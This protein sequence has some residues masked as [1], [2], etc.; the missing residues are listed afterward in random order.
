MSGHRV[1]GSVAGPC[2]N[3]DH[4][5]YFLPGIGDAAAA[6]GKLGF[7]LTPFS[8]QSH[9]L[10]ANGPL[11]PAGTGNRCVMLEHGYL[12]FLAPTHDTPNA[13]QLRAAISRYTGVHLV[14]FGTVTP[15]ADHQR[16]ASAHF[17][18]LPPVALQREVGTEA[19]MATARFTVVRVP[20]ATMAEGRIQYCRHHTPEVV[21]QQRWMRHANHAI[22]LAGVVVC[23]ADAAEAAR[24]YA[25][26]TG[27]AA[28]P[29]GTGWRL[30][31]AR[32]FL[33]FA[34]PSALENTLGLRAAVL[35]WIAG[36]VLDCDDMDA[37]R[38][39]TQGQN[40]DGRLLVEPD[41]SLGG[42]MIFQPPDSEPLALA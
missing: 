19:G 21:W 29:A 41:A 16:L 35:P 17:A 20:P 1:V 34:T 39:A 23:V 9:R 6:L 40:L 14:A 42:V 5:A 37:A 31:T 11:V 3:I 4:I 30:D 13:A 10:E 26:F 25:R 18:P 22:G 15:D 7:T 28:R 12:E 38:A 32:G 36:P 24:R 8:A 33:L 27:L 2:P